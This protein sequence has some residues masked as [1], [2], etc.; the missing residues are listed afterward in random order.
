MKRR[1]KLYVS[2]FILL[3]TRQ[4]KISHSELNLFSSVCSS[5]SKDH[6]KTMRQSIYIKFYDPPILSN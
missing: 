1:E 6:S 4:D 2:S 5:T 3:S